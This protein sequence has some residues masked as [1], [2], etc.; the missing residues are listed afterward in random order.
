[1]DG[2]A[3]RAICAHVQHAH[4]VARG[5]GERDEHDEE[6]EGDALAGDPEAA[7]VGDASERLLHHLRGGEQCRVEH[8]SAPLGA[9]RDVRAQV[10]ATGMLQRAQRLVAQRGDVRRD[11]EHR[12]RQRGERQVVDYARVVRPLVPVIAAHVDAHRPHEA[13]LEEHVARERQQEGHERLH[14]VRRLRERHGELRVP[15]HEHAHLAE[16]R[17]RRE[18]AAWPAVAQHGRRRA[19]GLEVGSRGAQH[20]REARH[21]AGHE[22]RA[23][24]PGDHPQDAH[25]EVA[26]GQVVA[27]DGPRQR[28]PQQLRDGQRHPEDGVHQPQRDRPP[29]GHPLA[30]AAHAGA[31]H[32]LGVVQGD[33]QVGA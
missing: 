7:A 1:M 12:Q 8:T 17:L 14:P 13:R 33:H 31:A 25:G 3:S 15:P 27:G 11:A 6:R 21:Q 16:R 19:D 10:Q 9:A 30:S 22:A 20:E 26:E 28:R 32:E 29:L 2:R 5:D 18:L 24:R 23:R 4:N